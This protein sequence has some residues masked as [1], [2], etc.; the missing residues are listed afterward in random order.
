MSSNVSD[1]L[2]HYPN[3]LGIEWTSKRSFKLKGYDFDVPVGFE[4]FLVS[5]DPTVD[6]F[7]MAKTPDIIRRY[8]NLLKQAPAPQ[9]I[10]ELGV[11]RGGSVAFLQLAANPERL[12][13]LEL[14][15]ERL[16]ILDK[17]TAT[18]KLQASLRVEYGV[19]QGDSNTVRRL[20]TEHFGAGRPI[21]LVIDDASHLLGPTRKSFETVFPMLRTGGSYVVED[22][23]ASHILTTKY[24]K[25][26][27]G[28]PKQ[29]RDVVASQ[30]SMSLPADRK[31][32][33]LLA[34]ELM[35]AS[36]NAPQIISR[37]TV[38]RHWLRVIRGA[39]DV[40]TDNGFDLRA[41]AAD[42]FSLLESAPSAAIEAILDGRRD[43]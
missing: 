9:K 6:V 1:N 8:I 22:F 37:V 20:A 36:I 30:L 12:L 23:A 25:A 42:H 21:D 4:D 15:N 40:S 7:Y 26:Q 39:A 16:P 27:N 24:A 29:L 5:D 41:L 17:F 33:H 13:A 35:L 19:D 43:A 2:A 34:V 14:S 18:E 31:P 32:L 11:F 3:G 38:D 10:L 28:G